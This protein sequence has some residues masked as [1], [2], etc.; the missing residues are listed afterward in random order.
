MPKART[1]QRSGSRF[2]V[3]PDRDERVPGVTSILNMVPKPFL[4]FWA[5]KVVAECAVDSLPEVVGLAMRDR[6]GAIDYL[7][8]APRRDTA[9]AAD[10][11]SAVH[12]MFERIVRG[13][14]LTRLDPEMRGYES[15]IKAFLDRFSPRFLYVEDTVWSDTHQYAGSF[16][17]IVEIDG[18]VVILDVKTTRSGVH[19]DV[20]LQ[21]AAYAH[22]DHIVGQD[23]RIHD[24]PPIEAGAVLHLRPEGWQLVPARVD[25]HVF[26]QF[27]VL[28]RV[29]DLM[30]EI[31]SYIGSPVYDSTAATSTG[32]QRRAARR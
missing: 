4:T 29:F 1:I 19:S 30:Q 31:D 17:A 22:A 7:K 2:Y 12:E 18:E 21:L 6:Q 28:R 8:G 26:D 23:D 9:S 24:I 3:R 15:H 25:Q 27:L 32:A 13:D 11:G 14:R 16:D 5:A 20:A 10:R